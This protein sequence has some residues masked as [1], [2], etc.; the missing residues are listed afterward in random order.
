MSRFDPFLPV[1]ALP[2]GSPVAGSSRSS[3][4]CSVELPRRAAWRFL[5]R[6]VLCQNLSPFLP[7]ET[8]R[9]CRGGESTPHV[10]KEVQKWREASS[11]IC[12]GLLSS[13]CRQ[14]GS[15]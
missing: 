9:N 10:L 14:N 15:G 4:A 8:W 3:V 11:G 13:S 7:H 6:V 5:R 12:T 2:I 1:C